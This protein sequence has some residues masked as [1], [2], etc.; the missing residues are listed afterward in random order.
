MVA[1]L[2]EKVDWIL[3]KYS[4][5]KGSLIID[6][7]S[8]DG[9]TLKAYPFEGYRLVGI[10]PTA[11][12]FKNFYPDHI[13]LISD[14]FS[15]GAI[16]SHLGSRK[17]SVVTSFSMFYDLESPLNFM[18]EVADILDVEGIWV[19]EQSYMPAMLH[20]NAYDTVCHEHLEYYAIEQIHWMAQRCGLRLIEVD[21]DGT[22][23][24]SFAIVAAKDGSH[25]KESSSV[26]RMLSKE[27]GQQ[28]NSLAPYRCFSRRVSECRDQLRLFFDDARAKGDRT[29]V[30]GASTKGNVL[31]QYCGVTQTD[32]EKVGEINSDKFGCFTPGGLLPITSEAEVLSDDPDYL[33]VLPWH[34]RKFFLEQP[35]YRGRKLVFPLPQLEILQC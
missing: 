29:S 1:H 32:V 35:Q 8:N 12:K 26:A 28:L 20:M 15:A 24:G 14:F 27:R 34:F 9:T 19:L 16:R 13:Q 2:H 5:P 6:I 30:L 4:P 31:L 25:Y 17:A 33:L 11:V 22:N 18:Q 21:T 7:G 3:K 10:D 23:G